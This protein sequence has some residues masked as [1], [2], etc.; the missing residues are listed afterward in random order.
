MRRIGRFCFYSNIGDSKTNSQIHRKKQQKTT[1]LH[2]KNTQTEQKPHDPAKKTRAE[3]E[4]VV[5]YIR[6]LK[7][8]SRRIN[9]S[10]EIMTE[11]LKKTNT[12]HTTKSDQADKLTDSTKKSLVTFMTSLMKC[13]KQHAQLSHSM[14]PSKIY[15][16]STI[17]Q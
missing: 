17:N 4:K 1:T 11:L 7:D 8:K 6:N 5:Q 12:D 2:E 16:F 14:T 15:K 10:V 13:K 9:T 3:I